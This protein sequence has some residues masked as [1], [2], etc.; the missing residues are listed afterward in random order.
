MSIS[1]GIGWAGDVGTGEVG[2]KH[3][4]NASRSPGSTGGE[5]T[6]ATTR[7]AGTHAGLSTG[8]TGRA[9][10]G[11]GFTLPHSTL[12]NIVPDRGSPV[13]HYRDAVAGRSS[14]D[15]RRTGPVWAEVERSGLCRQML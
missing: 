13:E 3:L 5:V 8:Y 10:S 4:S 9:L 15:R 6:A 2:T 11:A 1:V 12:V 14:H 7:S